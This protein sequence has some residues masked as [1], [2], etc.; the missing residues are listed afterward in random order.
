M[1]I[2]FVSEE[3]APY[4]TLSP[5]ADL[6]RILP[7]QLQESGEAEV[8][9]MMPRYGTI[10]ER[11]NRLHEVIRLSGSVIEVDGRK[12]TLK[13]KVASI[14]GVRMQVYFMDNKYYM[15][16]KGIYEDQEKGMFEDNPERAFFFSKS[17]L[18]TIRKLGWSPDVIHSFG[19][20]SAPVS[21]LMRSEFGTDPIYEK[22]KVVFTPG[23]RNE[24]A[25]VATDLLTP[26][27]GHVN[28]AADSGS[29]NKMSCEA[30][31]LVIH[32]QSGEEAQDC[33]IFPESV[34]EYAAFAKNLYDQMLGEVVV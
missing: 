13:V 5:I 6:V 15:K 27:L 7:E 33:D 14:P 18:T 31:D 17:V 26:Y 34:E 20:L 9:I 25:H 32:A 29:L 28:G 2:L 21:L 11:R 22:T 19:W 10:S 30:A 24:D 8:R 4:A 1:R 12:E 23:S 16:R 3:V